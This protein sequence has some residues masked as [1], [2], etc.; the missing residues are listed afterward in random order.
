MTPLPFP[1]EPCGVLKAAA[2]VAVSNPFAVWRA[3]SEEENEKDS[4]IGA[5]SGRV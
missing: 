3:P 4:D 5:S 2:P 1:N